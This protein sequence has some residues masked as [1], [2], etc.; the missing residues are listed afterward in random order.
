MAAS[1]GA[2]PPSSSTTRA[3]GSVTPSTAVM[4]WKRCDEP[5]PWDR[6]TEYEQD[7]EVFEDERGEVQHATINV[8]ATGRGHRCRVSNR[9][10][11]SNL[12]SPAV[13][14]RHRRDGTDFAD[15]RQLKWKRLVT[16]ILLRA[17]RSH[18]RGGTSRRA[19]LGVRYRHDEK[20]RARRRPQRSPCWNAAKHTVT[21]EARPWGC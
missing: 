17:D 2:C 15:H 1:C 13:H 20:A 14:A 4:R 11:R 18:T 9:T 5:V 12:A 16:G 21:T 19:G 7:G 10:G 8:I 6:N 3:F